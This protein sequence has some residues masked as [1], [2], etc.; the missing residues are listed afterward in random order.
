MNYSKKRKAY[1]AFSAAALSAVMVTIFLLSAENSTES[2][3]TSGGIIQW[4]MDVLSVNIPSDVIRT[5]AHI[6]EFALLGFLV[7][8]LFISIKDAP[9]PLLSVALSWG[10]AWTDEIHQLF[11]DGRAF[12]L[13]DLTVD[14]TGIILGTALLFVL[15]KLINAKKHRSRK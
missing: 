4:I 1:I 2:A 14:L 9:K 13:I 3:E 15:F 5:F 6:A 7:S 12:Q 11:V 8:N 10:Y